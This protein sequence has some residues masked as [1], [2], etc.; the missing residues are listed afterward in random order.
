[1]SLKQCSIM[2]KD[3][4]LRCLRYIDQNISALIKS[5]AFLQIDQD[6]LCVILE[7]D[8]LKINEIEIWNAALRWA[9]EQCRQNDIECSTEN[10]RKM[11][12]PALFNIRFSLISK[13]D[14][15]KS[16]VPTDVLTMEEVDSI[17]QQYSHQ[18]LSDVSEL[19][20]L[21]FPTHQRYKYEE[22]IEM[23]IE[24]VS[25]FALEEVRSRRFS[26]AVEIGGFSWKIMAKIR[27]GNEN[28]ENWLGVFLKH[29]GTESDKNQNGNW[30]RKCSATL[31]IVSQKSGVEDFMNELND[32]TVYNNKTKS[33]GFDDFISFEELMEPSKGLYNKDEDKVTLAID[34]TCE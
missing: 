27:T 32:E 8:L 4:A 17:Y 15:T 29:D 33:W 11:L 31:R 19:Y 3:F 6:L 23:E 18:K 24:K 25:E 10:R 16:V 34:F 1:M 22:T 28:N 26:D 12:G 7:R 2:T 21:K 30:S 20:K 14:F 13:E 5:E 9:D